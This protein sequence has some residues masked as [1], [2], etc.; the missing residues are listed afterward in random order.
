MKRAK[1]QNRAV[2][3]DWK[4]QKP[5]IVGSLCEVA[6]Q[7]QKHKDWASVRPWCKNGLIISR[8]QTTTTNLA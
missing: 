7:K 6:K 2:S 4:A 3:Y 1:E 8:Q 5:S